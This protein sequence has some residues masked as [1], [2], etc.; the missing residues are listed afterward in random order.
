VPDCHQRTLQC[1]S[2]GSALGLNGL[3]NACP[4]GLPIS[5]GFLFSFRSILADRDGLAMV[6]GRR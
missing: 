6:A 2:I 3:C 5:I 1:M 4:L